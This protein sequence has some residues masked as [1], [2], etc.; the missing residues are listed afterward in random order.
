MRGFWR[1]LTRNRER[2][3]QSAEERPVPSEVSVEEFSHQDVERIRALFRAR[4]APWWSEKH[5]E[6]DHWWCGGCAQEILRGQGYGMITSDIHCASCTDKHMGYYRDLA[7]G[8]RTMDAEAR[9][10]LMAAREYAKTGKLRREWLMDG[11]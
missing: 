6:A 3:L 1:R 8:K 10:L 2:G 7:D 11:C 5:K 9:A 4:I